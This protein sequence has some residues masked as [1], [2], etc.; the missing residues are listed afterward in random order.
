MYEDM[1]LSL[2]LTTA[3]LPAAEMCLFTDIS[4]WTTPETLSLLSR[5]NESK[6]KTANH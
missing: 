2:H 3:T 6:G 5:S 1:L 4:R